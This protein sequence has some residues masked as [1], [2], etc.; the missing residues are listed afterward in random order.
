MKK[1]ETCKYRVRH[2]RYPNVK[3]DRC[4]IN[5]KMCRFMVKCH[6]YSPE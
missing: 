4:S 5:G 3:Y 1:C 2:N 6:S